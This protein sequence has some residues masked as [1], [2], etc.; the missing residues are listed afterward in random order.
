[1][2]PGS[3][4]RRFPKQPKYNLWTQISFF[5]LNNSALPAWLLPA[6]FSPKHHIYKNVTVYHISVK[7]RRPLSLSSKVRFLGESLWL[8]CWKYSIIL[9]TSLASASVNTLQPRIL[10]HSI[11]PNLLLYI[12][13]QIQNKLGW[14]AEPHQER[15]ACANKWLSIWSVGR[16]LARPRDLP[17]HSVT[18][19]CHTSAWMRHLGHLSEEGWQIGSARGRSCPRKPG[20]SWPNRA[21][22][23]PHW[24]PHPDRRSHYVYRKAIVH[25]MAPKSHS[26]WLAYSSYVWK[27][28][29]V[30]SSRPPRFGL[31]FHDSPESRGYQTNDIPKT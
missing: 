25:T 3:S 12:A 31:S 1:M 29:S 9:K 4:R 23:L 11:F 15:S 28:Y 14:E 21:Y 26:C 30:R 13:L 20:C 18:C 10:D 19:L 8:S 2:T 27:S 5:L 6:Y 22:V 24:H 7:S 16:I 17:E